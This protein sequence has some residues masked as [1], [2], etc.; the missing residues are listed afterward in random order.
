ML[1]RLI[2]GGEVFRADRDH[3]HH[4]MVRLGLTPR[5]AVILLYGVS[6]LLGSLALAILSGPQQTLWAVL[7]VVALLGWL[8]VHRLGY[9]EV[10]ELRQ[11]LTN[12]LF[13]SRRATVNNL[14]LLEA[15]DEIAA[16]ASIEEGWHA[17][18]SVAR[19]LGFLSLSLD[20]PAARFTWSAEDAAL[21]TPDGSCTWDVPVS[22]GRLE[23]VQSAAGALLLDIPR[24]VQLADAL[25][26][27]V[28]AEYPGAAAAVG[29]REATGAVRAAH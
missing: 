10:S 5:R 18:T 14:R 24:V 6:V 12:R 28:A 8:G 29:L 27:R 16:A 21:R 7:L 9:V 13:S 11:V 19:E 3:I 22:R 1:R 17:V 2:R 15:R 20:L 26:A 4:R 25:S 23:A